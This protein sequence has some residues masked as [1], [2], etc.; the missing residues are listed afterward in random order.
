[1]KLAIISASLCLA[2]C[3]DAAA[4]QTV[5]AQL[6]VDNEFWLYTGSA[7]G[8]NLTLRG[9]GNNHNISYSFTFNVAPGEHLFIAA[10]DW[11]G[12]QA[13]QGVFN[14]PSG[15]LYSSI[16]SWQY[17][18]APNNDASQTAVQSAVA[19]ATWANPQAQ[20]SYNS[21]P[22]GA[23]VNNPNANWMWHDNVFYNS[24]SDGRYAIFRTKDAV[25]AVP[26]AQ[27]YMM[28]L[29]GLLGLAALAKRKQA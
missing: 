16:N 11:G 25:A 15:M 29:A 10:R 18:I 27:T 3:C 22:W 21:Y 24:S 12:P 5:S 13:W 28:M 19:N 1:M 20:V 26:E 17:A 9:T 2:F 14:T 6:T 4:A 8:A 7:D 23:S